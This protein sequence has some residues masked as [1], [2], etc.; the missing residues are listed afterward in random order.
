MSTPIVHPYVYQFHYD[1]NVTPH[2]SRAIA[3]GKTITITL[4][5]IQGYLDDRAANPLPFLIEDPA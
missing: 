3:E 1:G 2:L 5:T 4:D